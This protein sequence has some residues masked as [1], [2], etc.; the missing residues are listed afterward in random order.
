MRLLVDPGHPFS[1]RLDNV[2]LWHGEREPLS[3]FCTHFVMQMLCEVCHLYFGPFR[4]NCD[5]RPD[6]LEPAPIAS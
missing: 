4:T 6:T 2:R 3:S 5:A 1:H